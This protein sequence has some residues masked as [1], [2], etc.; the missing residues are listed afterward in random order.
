MDRRLRKAAFLGVGRQTLDCRVFG[1]AAFDAALGSA[2]HSPA[3]NATRALAVATMTDQTRPR[4]L[5]GVAK[6]FFP[7]GSSS[8]RDYLPEKVAEA[9]LKFLNACYSTGKLPVSSSRAVFHLIADEAILRAVA[10]LGRRFSPEFAPEFWDAFHIVDDPFYIVES[11][12]TLAPPN[13]LELAEYR[14]Q[15]EYLSALSPSEGALKRWSLEELEHVVLNGRFRRLGGAAL[16]LYGAFK[17][18]SRLAPSR[19][20]EALQSRLRERNGLE[21][22]KPLLPFLTRYFDSSYTALFHEKLFSRAAGERYVAGETLARLRD[23]KYLAAAVARATALLHPDG[24]IDP[25]N[26]THDGEIPLGIIFEPTLSARGVR[27]VKRAK[28]LTVFGERS[29]FQT[30][31]G[32]VP[33][34]GWEAYFQAAPEEIV[35][36]TVSN[37]FFHELLSGFRE[38][39]CMFGGSLAWLEALSRPRGVE[40]DAAEEAAWL[41]GALRFATTQGATATREAID[42]LRAIGAENH[43]FERPLLATQLALYEPYPWREDFANYFDSVVWGALQ[44]FGCERR[45]PLKSRPLRAMNYAVSLGAFTETEEKRSRIPR[46]FE[47]VTEGNKWVRPLRMTTTGSWRD[48]LQLNV[49]GKFANLF[50]NNVSIVLPLAP[51]RLRE[52]YTAFGRR[53][54]ELCVGSF[55]EATN[56]DYPFRGELLVF[57]AVPLYRH[58][59]KFFGDDRGYEPE[60]ATF[61]DF[62]TSETATN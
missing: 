12:E 17:T 11:F 28:E 35:A 30:L 60:I 53:F 25:T 37:G 23:P 39:F 26:T 50:W 13:A 45:P 7:D 6:A 8:P 38:S 44:K 4:E 2:S 21:W 19:A 14:G 27:Y 34:R 51:R 20:K 61:E 40:T 52:K 56:R 29:Y 58:S 49:I 24:R 9:T 62:I 1:G 55:E 18:L 57:K 15:M 42:R 43:F 5:K 47:N 46:V 32:R 48:T 59:V 3:R 31:F 54:H 22:F 41:D 33:L 36:K 10:R 16:E